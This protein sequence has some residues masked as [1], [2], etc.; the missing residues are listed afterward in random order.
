MEFVL[1]AGRPRLRRGGGEVRSPR[2]HRWRGAGR[3]RTGGARGWSA[4]RARFWG[5]GDTGTVV[6]YMY[7]WL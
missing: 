5:N 4:A 1:C 3:G 2:S 6:A 7:S